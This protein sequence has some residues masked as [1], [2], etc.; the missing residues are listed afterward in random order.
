MT[1]G[2]VLEFVLGNTFAFVV[3]CSYGK[4]SRSRREASLALVKW[5]NVAV[6]A[7]WFTEG[8]TLTPF[9]GAYAA[10]APADAT[11]PMDGFNSEGFHAT[12]GE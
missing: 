12:Y 3:F 7:Y 10:Y 8:I 1:L 4:L 11:N 5:S 2:G 6:G 9:Y